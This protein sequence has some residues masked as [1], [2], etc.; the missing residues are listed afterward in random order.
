MASKLTLDKYYLTT[1]KDL[2]GKGVLLDRRRLR[3]QM[4][5]LEKARED[6]AEAFEK[7]G[8]LDSQSIV[9]DLSKL[10]KIFQL[11]KLL[12]AIV[13]RYYLKRNEDLGEV[14]QDFD[15]DF[16]EEVDFITR[17]KL[18][19]NLDNKNTLFKFRQ[20]FIIYLF[21]I[22]DLDDRLQK[23]S[24]VEESYDEEPSIDTESFQEE[25]P[26]DYDN[27]EGEIED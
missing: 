8:V 26:L 16:K 20:D 13:Y 12:L 18:F 11:N 21:L 7:L 17:N 10:E 2:Q 19:K 23:G 27:Y 22:I 5:P 1:K 14:L 9:S 4:S 25:E 6:L 3:T 24:F 15:N